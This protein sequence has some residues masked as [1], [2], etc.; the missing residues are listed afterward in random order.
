MIRDGDAIAHAQALYRAT[1]GRMKKKPRETVGEIA[2]AEGLK[3]AAL[4][5]ANG[6]LAAVYR[7]SDERVIDLDGADLARVRP[8]LLHRKVR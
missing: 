7:V 1:C 4:F 2:F 6:K 5:D 8:K 3:L